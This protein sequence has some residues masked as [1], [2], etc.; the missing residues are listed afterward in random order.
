MT[1][2]QT[3]A[4]PIFSRRKRW[5]NILLRRDSG[6][7]AT[8]KRDES[9]GPEQFGPDQS[10]PKSP[11]SRG[12]P[13]YETESEEK[14][15]DD[16]EPPKTEND[17]FVPE[18]LEPQPAE[19]EDGFSAVPLSPNEGLGIE[20]LKK[21]KAVGQVEPDTLKILESGPEN[22]KENESPDPK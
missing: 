20:N 18:K 19:D 8:Q 14:N 6:E 16:K 2:V 17:Y 11:L 15:E 22:P 10:Y 21:D 12:F 7:F 13:A 3:C 5:S 9:L 4:L 1:G